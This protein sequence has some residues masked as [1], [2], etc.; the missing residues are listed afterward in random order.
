MLT[1]MLWKTKITLYEINVV[2]LWE[3]ASVRILQDLNVCSKYAGKEMKR[4][5]STA[6]QAIRSK[7]QRNLS[8]RPKFEPPW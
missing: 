7:G 3:T 5:A 1:G 4:K 6:I 8:Q 2:L